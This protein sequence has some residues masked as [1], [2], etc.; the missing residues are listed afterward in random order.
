MILRTIGNTG[1]CIILILL[2]QSTVT[3]CGACLVRVF[4]LPLILFLLLTIHLK[5]HLD[6]FII[7]V[8]LDICSVSSL[9]FEPFYNKLVTFMFS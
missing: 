9:P 7:Y 2:W 4:Y 8:K 6:L 1:I 5:Y 3:A